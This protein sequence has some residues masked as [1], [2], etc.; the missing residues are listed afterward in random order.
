MR[1]SSILFLGLVFSTG[2]GTSK[3]TH[4][5]KDSHIFVDVKNDQMNYTMMTRKDTIGMNSNDVA[6]W[7]I[8][9]IFSPDFDSLKQSIYFSLENDYKDN[10]GNRWM[11]WNFD[12]RGAKGD[13]YRL[14]HGMVRKDQGFGQLLELSWGN[15]SFKS[16]LRK[17]P[18]LTMKEDGISIGAPMIYSA[19]V[20]KPDDKDEVTLNWDVLD[21]FT[22]NLVDQ[23]NGVLKV[24]FEGKNS[25]QTVTVFVFTGVRAQ[26]VQWPAD[27]GG[28]PLFWKDGVVV[29]SVPAQSI[30]E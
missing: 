16:P 29:E 25:N 17:E 12:S 14:I 28:V 27:C 2:C 7:G 26:R 19:I 6:F 24:N 10:N 3:V 1:Y 13:E 21:N 8:N 18:F 15:M 20:E 4:E 5:T 11:E 23:K 30:A 9:N 22:I